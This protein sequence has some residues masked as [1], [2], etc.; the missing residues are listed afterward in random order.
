MPTTLEIKLFNEL[1]EDKEVQIYPANYKG[2]GVPLPNFDQMLLDALNQKRN[3]VISSNTVRTLNYG[4]GVQ[5]QN[6]VLTSYCVQHATSPLDYAIRSRLDA[7]A[8]P[9][10]GFRLT[11]F[12]DTVIDTLMVDLGFMRTG[13]VS[14]HSNS[15]LIM[16]PLDVDKLTTYHEINLPM[17]IS[18]P[19]VYGLPSTFRANVTRGTDDEDNGTQNNLSNV[20]SV[21][22]F[23]TLF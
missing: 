23:F 20:K 18:E 11:P 17:K 21:T 19:G 14:A 15:D 22:L 1:Y 10:V 4:A 12:Y 7:G 16:L 8:Y 5:F 3:I 6:C 2:V 9:G 13:V